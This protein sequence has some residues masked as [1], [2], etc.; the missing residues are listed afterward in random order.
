M[1]DFHF[2][3]ANSYE[4]RT[5]TDL[6]ELL[7]WAQK[8]GRSWGL[9]SKPDYWAFYLPLPASANYEINWYQPQVDGA[10]YLGSYDSKGRKAN[11]VSDELQTQSVS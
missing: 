1:T 5:G 7:K 6:T 8:Y 4:W 11:E 3:V 2:Y 10:V 9:K